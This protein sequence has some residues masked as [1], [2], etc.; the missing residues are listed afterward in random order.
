[1]PTKLTKLKIDEVSSVDD[2]ANPGARIAIIKRD[3]SALE[4]HITKAF[5]AMQ[6]SAASIIES[7][8]SYDQQLDMLDESFEQFESYLTKIIEHTNKQETNM[9]VT[10]DVAKMVAATGRPAPLYS[11]RDWYAEIQKRA[12]ACKQEGES[13]AQ[14]FSR[15]IQK[16][17]E[18]RLL[19]EAYRRT[20]GAVNGTGPSEVE[21][22][23]TP[24]PL[25]SYTKLVA[26]GEE[27]RKADPKLTKEQAFVKA[28]T[29]PANRELVARYK[30]EDAAQKEDVLRKTG[31][32]TPL[33]VPDGYSGF[34]AKPSSNPTDDPES[35]GLLRLWRAWRLASPETAPKDISEYLT[36]ADDYGARTRSDARSRLE[37]RA[38]ALARSTSGLDHVTA[39]RRVA[40]ANPELLATASYQNVD[41]LVA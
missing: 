34:P 27:L 2:G 20:P 4:Q 33:K 41:Q 31:A 25:P 30:R 10:L 24:T 36:K 28:Y 13:P 37:A 29:D 35:D 5:A 40:A 23:S 22:A 9:D 1:M 38:S 39:L 16:N 19:Y 14:A 11:K 12:E 26:K 3:G 7:D 32:P 15:F 21:K 8:A 18:G 6:E 17:P